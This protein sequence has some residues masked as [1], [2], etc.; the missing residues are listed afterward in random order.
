MNSA[1][2]GYFEL[3]FPKPRPFL[4]PAAYE[5]QS[6]RAAFLA[7]LR[8]AK[9]TR[10]FMPHYICDS[11]LSPLEKAG[12]ECCFYFIDSDF[13]VIDDFDFFESDWLFYVN[14]FGV[15]GKNIERLFETYNPLQLILDH[16]QA[17]YT[18]PTNCLATIYSARKFF[19]VPD[20][21][22]LITSLPIREPQTIDHGSL[23]RA[24]PGLT[25]LAET[26]EAGYIDYQKSEYT[27]AQC[28]PLK[29][30]HLSRRILH[31]VNF[32]SARLR[33][34]ENFYFLHLRLG[35]LNEF[36]FD[37]RGIDGPLCYPFLIL[38]AGLRKF[39]IGERVFV[40]NYWP[41]ISGRGR[42]DCLEMRFARDLLP[43][44]CDQR[45]DLQDMQRVAELC[46][47]FLSCK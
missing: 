46:L 4:Y 20:G 15:C 10:V 24:I 5:F 47:N 6:A 39:L 3:E 31:S 16:S 33:R 17:F 8:A 12:V 18:P 19:G 30:S 22:L 43:L 21:G 35:C 40:A 1:I 37:L 25:R 11:M 13:N 32:E 45:Y 28:E 23:A 26:P 29:M 34:N 36:S 27:L 9:P 14:Y 2:G 44:P 41:E 7:Q 38:S 42:G